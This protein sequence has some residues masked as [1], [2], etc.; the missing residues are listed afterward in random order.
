MSSL[1]GTLSRPILAV[2]LL[3]ALYPLHAE[4]PNLTT[5]WIAGPGSRVADVPPYVWLNDGTAILEDG[6]FERLDP[7]TAKRHPILDMSRAVASLKSIDPEMDVHGKLPWPIAFDPPGKQALYLFNGDIFLLDLG[8]AAFHRLIHTSEE[9]KDP[10]FSP[11]G[12]FVSFVRSNNLYVWDLS[13]KKE[14][15]LTHDGSETTLNGT[16]SWVYWEEVFGRHDTAYWWSPDSASIAYLQTDE[17]GVPVSTFV[18]FS[19]VN[20]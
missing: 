3:S 16:L 18:D 7:V 13:A 4:T 1:R 2:L 10:Q 12:R 6:T 8:S 14:T 11:N 17:A 9:E 19:P 20:P 5:E 15:Q